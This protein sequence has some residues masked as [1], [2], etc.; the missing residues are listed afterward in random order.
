MV[1]VVVVA[2]FEI[3]FVSVAINVSCWLMLVVCLVGNTSC[4]HAS[5][6][7]TS[8]GLPRPCTPSTS[9]SSSLNTIS[10]PTPTLTDELR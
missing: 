7:L 10:T 2:D 6:W 8:D 4:S 9:S 1:L 5:A 3:G